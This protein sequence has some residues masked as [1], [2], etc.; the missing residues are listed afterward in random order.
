MGILGRQALTAPELLGQLCNPLMNHSQCTAG[1]CFIR[2][3]LIFQKQQHIA[4][5]EAA[6]PRKQ[7]FRHDLE[8]AVM[9]VSAE[10][11]GDDRYIVHIHVVQCLPQQTNVIGRAAAAARLKLNERRPARI[12]IPTGQSIK[13]LERLSR[14]SCG[15]KNMK[16]SDDGRRI[17]G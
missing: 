7:H 9:F 13:L 17:I 15:Q 12:K 11:H 3:T 6:E 5:N 1:A 4:V 16:Q 14:T 8:A 10:T 2:Q